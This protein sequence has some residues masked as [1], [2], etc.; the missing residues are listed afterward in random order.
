MKRQDNRTIGIIKWISSSGDFG[1]INA[2]DPKIEVFLHISNWLDLIDLNEINEKDILVFET[3][4]EKGKLSAINCRQFNYTIEDFNIIYKILIKKEN[5][6]I[7]S[8]QNNTYNVVELLDTHNE[9]IKNLY[10]YI[11]SDIN[12]VIENEYIVMLEK[13]ID[14]FGNKIMN[15]D[16][17][18]RH[19]IERFN[20]SNN[21]NFRIKLIEKDFMDISKV[22]FE[23]LEL[24]FD[25]YIFLTDKIRKHPEF[26][27]NILYILK[28][29]QNEKE[30]FIDIFKYAINHNCDF[31]IKDIYSYTE[32]IDKEIFTTIIGKLDN[33]DLFIEYVFNNSN[34]QILFKSIINEFEKLSIKKQD[35]LIE[36]CISGIEKL[37]SKNQILYIEKLLDMK[38]SKMINFTNEKMEIIFNKIIHN[39]EFSHILKY[40]LET[41]YTFVSNIILKYVRYFDKNIFIILINK[42]INLKDIIFLILKE[43]NNQELLKYIIAEFDNFSLDDYSIFLNFGKN[44]LLKLN[45]N[46]QV[47]Y[48]KKVFHLR[49]LKKIV[50]TMIDLKELRNTLETTSSSI[51]EYDVD[52]STFLILDLIIHFDEKN[53]FYV[54]S[55]LLNNVLKYWKLNNTKVTSIENYFDKCNGYGRELVLPNNGKKIIKSFFV[56]KNGM[57]KYYY[58]IYFD[59]DAKLVQLIKQFY[60][61]KYNEE[62][63]FWGVPARC[64]QE[65]IKFGKQNNF[66]INIDTNECAEHNKQFLYVE[67]REREKPAGYIFCCGHESQKCSNSGNKFW[68]CNGGA[69]Y[70][71]NITIHENWEEYTLFDLVNIMGFNLAE[72]SKDGNFIYK[73]GLYTR[74][75][76]ILNKFDIFLKHIYCHDCGNILYP[77]ETSNY[78]GSLATTYVCKNEDCP[79]NEKEIYLNNCLNGQCNNIIDS[80][81]SKKCPNGWYIC[82]ECGSCCSTI[83]MDNRIKKLNKVGGKISDHLR[84]FIFEK[85]GHLEKAEYCCYNCGQF[86]IEV[87]NNLYKC[88]DCGIEYD[89]SK[90]SKI[91]N[92]HIYVNLRNKNY[93]SLEQYVKKE[94]KQILL[95][96]KK[97]LIQANRTRGEIFGILFNKEVNINNNLVTLKQINDKNLTNEIFD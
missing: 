54:A 43:N 63:K 57:K 52:Y 18:Y 68:W 74:F 95:K 61:R 56:G 97:E 37:N 22:D 42:M 55:E 67:K 82:K 94:L 90:Y 96:E 12:K 64:E 32:Y 33:I 85:K 15:R 5:T 59:Y 39:E 28:I 84:K 24:N 76:E 38:L 20:I 58:K 4:T 79:S 91:H 36:F 48:L 51:Y 17:I 50:L 13:Y 19:T 47:L 1:V 44:N 60:G 75:V 73:I 10:S 11:A 46:N 27:N 14:R 72:H 26:L 3:K 66:Y 70:D 23:F 81:E 45:E 65:V 88:N 25:K 35:I 29:F 92:K 9:N 16:F 86:M 77:S 49:V 31:L 2:I 41:N 93:P 87:S 53:E 34:N 62:G 30:N 89:L 7:E 21:D 8:S 69:C 6:Q 71:N 78:H 40:A 80:R 83:A